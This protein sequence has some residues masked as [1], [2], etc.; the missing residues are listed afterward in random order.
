MAKIAELVEH[1][2]RSQT[3]TEG[4]LCKFCYQRTTTLEDIS[5]L[6]QM[7]PCQKEILGQ[8]P[9]NFSIYKHSSSSCFWRHN[10]LSLHMTTPS[11]YK[12]SFWLPLCVSLATTTCSE[13]ELGS[14]EETVWWSS[15]TMPFHLIH[16][17]D[18]SNI[19]LHSLKTNS[20]SSGL[21]CSE[22]CHLLWWGVQRE[23]FSDFLLSSLLGS[24]SK[25]P[26]LS[27]SLRGVFFLPWNYRHTPPPVPG[28]CTYM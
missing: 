26:G 10:K 20:C 17:C 18:H 2:H 28:H 3:L 16:H 24:H 14:L 15:V 9:L 19:N 5:K 8:L 4:K 11:F 7:T 27:L 12:M 13:R 6:P 21:G 23:Q 25:D 22:Q 1:S